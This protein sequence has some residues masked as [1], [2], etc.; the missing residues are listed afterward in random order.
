MDFK[1]CENRE[2][3]YLV[4]YI[5]PLL[6]IKN[7][8]ISDTGSYERYDMIGQIKNTF[9]VFEIKC[10][11]NVQEHYEIMGLAM[12]LE[13][14]KS[15][16][17]LYPDHKIIYINVLEDNRIYIFRVDDILSEIPSEDGGGLNMY[18]TRINCPVSECDPSRGRKMKPVILLPTKNKYTKKYII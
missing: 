17:E 16:K 13:K 18:L 5:I 1:E 12:E 2:R 4:N 15:L 3:Y 10:R 6:D 8:K 11:I 14:Y 9:C 7:E